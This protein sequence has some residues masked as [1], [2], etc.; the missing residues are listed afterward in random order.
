MKN[1]SNGR[2]EDYG[3]LVG[4]IGIL[5]NIMLFIFKLIMG[6]LSN[7]IS[8]TADAINNLS[9]AGSCGVTLASFKLAKKPADKKYPFGY[10]R[11]EYISGFIVAFLIII[12]GMELIKTSIHEIFHTERIIFNWPTLIALFLSILIKLGMGL[13]NKYANKKIESVSINASA[14]D[15]LCDALVT[16][17]ALFSYLAA[18][19]LNWQIDGYAGI[20]ASLFILWSGFK[21]AMDALKPLLGQSPDPKV[22]NQIKEKLLSN[23][24]IISIHDLMLHNYGPNHYYASVHVVVPSDENLLELHNELFCAEKQIEDSLNIYI[25]IHP[26]PLNP[27]HVNNGKQHI[28]FRKL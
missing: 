8:I 13:F 4:V 6:C 2:R 3:M 1:V 15:C 18:Y 27:Q 19:F 20:I 10:G 23:K 21:A 22:S 16:T 25:N 5:G 9:D 24:N 11:I 7:S 26:D 17:V 28:I 14:L 12:V